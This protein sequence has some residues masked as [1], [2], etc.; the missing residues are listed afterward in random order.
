M[1]YPFALCLT[2]SYA[3][4]VSVLLKQKYSH[5]PD[6]CQWIYAVSLSIQQASLFLASS[7]HQYLY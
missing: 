5:K 3:C 2:L 6:L 4:S 1:S 7:L